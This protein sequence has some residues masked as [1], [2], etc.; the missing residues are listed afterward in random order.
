LNTI[1]ININRI[2]HLLKLYRLSK[3][4]ILLYINKSRKRPV[5]EKEVFKSEIKTS[6]LKDIDSIFNKGLNYY[7]DPKTPVESKEESIF[8][9]KDHF[10]AELSLGAKQRVTQFE[11]EKIALSALAKLSNLSTDRILPEYKTQNNPKKVALDLR[12]I[13]FP[14]KQKNM[15]E[16]LKVFISNLADYNVT[17]FEFVDTH[18]KREKANINGFFLAPNILVLKRI[19]KS[20]R[21]EIFTLAHELGHYL[22]N[23]EEIDEIYE[24][25]NKNISLNT[26]EKWCND[27][28][29]YFLAGEHDQIISNISKV[30]SYNDYQDDFITNLTK[31]IPL[32]KTAIYTRLVISKQ[33]SQQ[34]YN[35]VQERIHTAYLEYEKS[36]QLKKELDKAKGIKPKGRTPKPII[37]PLVKKTLQSAYF[38]GIINEAEFCKR[39][40]INPEKIESYLQ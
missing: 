30:D 37:S 16:F 9:R 23:A 32:S 10:N 24:D 38:E 20:L 26:I 3:E 15:K 28:A 19:Q 22:L 6:Y 25:F 40:K 31:E 1:A 33:I 7:L 5:T 36:Q 39:L 34:T 27:F 4:D 17:V 13:L 18:N 29:Y 8:F 14:G 21:R 12:K 35:I 2:E 11:E